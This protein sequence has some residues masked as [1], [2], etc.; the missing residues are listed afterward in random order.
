MSNNIS[1][2][3]SLEPYLHTY[4]KRQEEFITSAD[5][6]FMNFNVD[7]LNIDDYF[8]FYNKALANLFNN[9]QAI[10]EFTQLI[11]NDE[12]Y[13]YSNENNDSVI[14]FGATFPNWNF[15][16]NALK[17]YKLELWAKIYI[18]A[19]FCTEMQSTQWVE[20]TNRLIKTE[21]GAKITLLNLGKAIQMKLEC[22][23]PDTHEYM[24]GYLEDEYDALQAS[25]ENLMN[26]VNHENILEI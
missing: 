11:Q 12:E 4:N 26:I 21:V 17:R 7:D 1:G 5:F 3:S 23:F 9:N 16:E 19:T 8:D 24:N 14:Q 15:L 13:E 25:L 10:N 22:E 6:S 18:F 20:Y 2:S